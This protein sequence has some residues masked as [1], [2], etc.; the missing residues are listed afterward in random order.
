MKPVSLL[1][2]IPLA[3]AAPSNGIKARGLTVPTGPVPE[4]VRVVGVSLLGSGCPAG[5][6]DVQI[7]ATKTLLEVTFSEYIIQTGPDTRASDW[8]KNCK[9]TLN[10]EFDEGFSFSTL[11]TDMSG[12]AQIPEGSKGLCTNTFDFTG[13]SGKTTYELELVG[14][15]EGAF[16]LSADPDVVSWSPCGGTTAIMNMNTQCNISPT[17][18]AA[19][20]AVSSTLDV[21]SLCFLCGSVPDMA[22][23]PKGRSYQRRNHRQRPARLAQVLKGWGLRSLLGRSMMRWLTKWRLMMSVQ[24]ASSIYSQS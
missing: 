2:L 23:V 15:I 1:S 21:L 11:A 20:I 8:R 16:T 19:L 18:D 22:F 13:I 7:D 17:K 9:L 24:F 14:E 6:A 12:F 10:M 5:T 4:N 3:A